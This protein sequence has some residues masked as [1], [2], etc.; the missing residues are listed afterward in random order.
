[1]KIGPRTRAKAVEL[2]GSLLEGYQQ[3]I[4]KTYCDTDGHLDISLK[5][6]LT[7]AGEHG[8]KI[9]AKISFVESKI[10]DAVFEVIDE[11]Q[12]ELEF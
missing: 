5:V 8:T 6:R 2:V 10:E 12:M 3:Q 1:M 4:E 7:P 11:E 9:T